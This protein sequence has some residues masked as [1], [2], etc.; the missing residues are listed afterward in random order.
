MNSKNTPTSRRALTSTCRNGDFFLLASRARMRSAWAS[1]AASRAGSAGRST[2]SPEWS[3]V[4]AK[5]MSLTSV[6]VAASLSDEA[7]SAAVPP[8]IEKCRRPKCAQGRPIRAHAAPA[9]CLKHKSA[10]SWLPGPPLQ[11]TLRVCHKIRTDEV[12]DER[13]NKAASAMTLIYF[14][15]SYLTRTSNYENGGCPTKLFVLDD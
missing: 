9:S 3:G 15:T 12:R 2:A 13:R 7:T 8:V 1:A 10:N 5:R 6:S 14:V 4:S 11:I